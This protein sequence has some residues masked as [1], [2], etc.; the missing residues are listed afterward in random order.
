MSDFETEICFVRRNCTPYGGAE[1]YLVRL[2]NSL[3]E[4]GYTHRL[5]HS[6]L[7][8]F[9]P[10][11]LRVMFF[12]LS[13]CLHKGQRFYFSLERIS[14]PDI[15]RAG[16]GVHREFLLS[17]NKSFNLLNPVYLFL[18]RRCFSNARKIIANS[19]MV[20]NDIIHHYNIDSSKIFVIYSGVKLD[21]DYALA[22]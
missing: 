20:R 3:T 19:M 21:I 14:C 22:G 18:E 8:K 15:Y 2:S 12:N 5:I 4:Q 16:D 17:K 6:R 11:F 7:P 1:N 9:L 10:S 13:V